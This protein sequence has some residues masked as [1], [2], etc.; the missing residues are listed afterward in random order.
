M[1]A[2]ARSGLGRHTICTCT[3]K[4]CGR[5]DSDGT[6]L[7]RV[8]ARRAP[9]LHLQLEP[10]LGAR[11]NELPSLEV[12]GDRDAPLRERWPVPPAELLRATADEAYDDN[13]GHER[14]GEER[15]KSARRDHRLAPEE[16]D[17]KQRHGDED[18]HGLRP[19]EVQQLAALRTKLA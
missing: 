12:R 5:S 3:H 8:H 7:A 4:A 14:R 15:A 11:A 6:H 18:G 19:R 13:V 10:E 2:A 17:H 9:R 16:E 1:P